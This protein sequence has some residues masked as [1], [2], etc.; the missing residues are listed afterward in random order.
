MMISAYLVT[1]LLAL[2]PAADPATAAGEPVVLT[3]QNA[4]D[5][6][7]EQSYEARRER[8]ILLS[9]E[10]NVQAQKGRFRTQA[11]LTLNAPYFQQDVQSF[12][13]PD[14]VPYY[15]TV[16]TLRWQSQLRIT[17]PLPTD[18]RFALVSNLY[19][20]RESV[21]KDQEDFTDKAKRF[22][23]SFRLEFSQPLL[24]P[25]SL[26][27]GMERANLQ[28]EQ[29]QRQYLR[30]ELDVVYEV[31]AAFYSLY[32]ATR[33]LEITDQE[34]KQ[35]EETNDLA[36]RKF[37]AGLIPEVEALQTEVDLAQSHNRRL[38]AEGALLRTEDEF[39][40]TVGLLLDEKV[41]VKTDFAMTE[42]QVDEQMAIDHG[43]KNRSEIREG[44]INRRLAE[45]T[46]KETD[47]RSTIHADISA[48]Y[49]LTGVSDPY[50]EYGS[51]VSQ[52][53]HSSISDLKRRPRN[54]GVTF[55]VS[56]PLWDSGVN[57]AEVAAARA[58]LDRNELTESENVRRVTQQIK[59]VLT[60]LQ[61]TRGRVDVLRRTQE[62]AERSYAISQA[63]F[64][65][66]DITSQEL[67]LDRER[68][69]QSRTNYLQAYIDYQ[70]AAADLKRNTLYDWE[71]GQSLVR[72]NF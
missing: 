44:Q 39:K 33:R 56:L 23:S 59:A 4:I 46:L 40:M 71:K 52:F 3:L 28:Y 5:L 58:T 61:E 27:L 48:Y 10:Q 29:A 32:S 24:V 57:R 21:F 69:T 42:F 22:Y 60:R 12:R 38:E 54:R 47:A 68:L 43:L 11:N 67:A 6:A 8:L 53:F 65:N 16:G 1:A 64:D 9:S 49:D 51:S 20:S 50:L 15:N 45:I 13:I 70:L 35:Q 37:G 72:D 25:N 2:S 34:V 26:K 19:H 31:T 55:T 36:Q 41:A 18:G 7:L 66:G 30:T 62:V 17:Q 14:E 63:R